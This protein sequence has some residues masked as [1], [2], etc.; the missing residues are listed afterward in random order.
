MAI[1]EYI[2]YY[3]CPNRAIEKM[4]SFASGG[5]PNIHKKVPT[6]RAAQNS[7]RVRLIFL[8]KGLALFN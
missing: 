2:S 7:F 4:K 3:S 6:S 8:T 5:K 1:L